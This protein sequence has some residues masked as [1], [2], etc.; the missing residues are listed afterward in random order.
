MTKHIQNTKQEVVHS[1]QIAET[2]EQVDAVELENV[3]GGC[4]RCGCGAG[5][6]TVD[7]FELAAS[8]NR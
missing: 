8:W 7:S 5:G 3:I 4:A 6:S 2:T 1:A